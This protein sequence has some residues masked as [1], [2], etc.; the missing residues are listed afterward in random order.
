MVRMRIE[1]VKPDFQVMYRQQYDRI[2]KY[3]YTLL[4]NRERAEDMVQET[5]L[6]AYRHYDSFDPAKGSVSTWLSRIAHNK[7][8]DQMRSA[9]CRLR[10]EW[11]E[12]ERRGETW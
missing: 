6:S 3:A 12:T 8:V 1:M 4:L 9:A 7:A 2:Y 10:V 11:P 5:F